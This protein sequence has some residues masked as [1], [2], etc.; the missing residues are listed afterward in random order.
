ME[1]SFVAGK[2]PAIKPIHFEKPFVAPDM[3]LGRR[4]GD[5]ASFSSHVQVRDLVTTGLWI[6]K[7]IK[8]TCVPPGFWPG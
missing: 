7:L 2:L 8:T 3:L 1:L 5:D 6:C 4:R